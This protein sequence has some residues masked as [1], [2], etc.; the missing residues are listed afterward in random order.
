MPTPTPTDGARPRILSGM[1]PTSDSLHLG[2]YPVK[3]MNNTY[4]S[5]FLAGQ[6]RRYSDEELE[7]LLRRLDERCRT[8]EF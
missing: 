1:Q 3:A 7:P 6:K 5:G 8:L 2:N 4:L